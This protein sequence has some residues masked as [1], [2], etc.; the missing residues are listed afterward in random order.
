[1]T[2]P[3]LLA[4]LL[5]APVLA[6]AQTPPTVVM[7]AAD[8]N[9]DLGADKFAAFRRGLKEAGIVEGRDAMVE[10]RWASGRYDQLDAMTSAIA[11]RQPAVVLAASLPSALAIK[12]TAPQLPMVFVIGADPVKQGLVAS[13]QKPGGNAT[14][15]SQLFGA[16]G[17]KRLQLLQ[18][19]VPS[20]KRVAVLSNPRN[21]NAR[22][23]IDE[24]KAAAR[25]LGISIEV[26]NASSAAEI[27]AAFAALSAGR[28][29]ALLVADDPFFNVERRRIV[30]LAARHKLATVHYSR[31]FVALGGLASYGSDS[32]ENYRIA[33]TY[34]AKILHGA[35]PADLPVLQ[36]TRF[37]LVVNARAARELGLVIPP[38]LKVRIDEVIE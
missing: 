26:V 30:S 13:L 38:S 16:L 23:H 6:L 34:V 28:A 19:L 25:G 1:M 36:P 35:K 29:P 32:R 24:V 17:G 7:L 33:G 21:A 9:D 15:I 37:E 8:A 11:A 10:V 5:A 2:F 18:E 12:R 20:A 4:A 3:R 31:D 22:G 14:G 27:D